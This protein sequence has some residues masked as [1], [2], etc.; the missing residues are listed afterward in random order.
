V[1]DSISLQNW[2]VP[3][4]EFYNP[5]WVWYWGDSSFNNTS[6]TKDVNTKAGHRYPYAGVYYL[7]LTQTD[8]ITGTALRCTN[9]FPEVNPDL[10]IQRKIKVIVKPIAPADFIISDSVVC[11]NEDI[12]FTDRSDLQYTRYQWYFGDGDSSLKQDPDSTAT[13]SY[14]AKGKYTIRMVPDYDPIGFVPKCVD[15]AA[16]TIRVV[17]VNA[18]FKIDSTLKP[19]FKFRNLSTGAVKYTWSLQ[20]EVDG[21]LQ[22][23]SNEFNMQH[24]WGELIGTFQVCLIAESA[25]GCTDTMCRDINNNFIALIIPY[26]V[27]TPGEDKNGDGFNDLYLVSVKGQ[28]EFE[29]KIYNR[30]GELVFETKDPNVGWDGTVMNKGKKE[31][32]AG[33]YFYIINYKL[34]NRP[35]NDGKDPISGSIT[36]IR[37]K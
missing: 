2:S 15:T 35:V 16:H 33:A 29:I 13:H 8:S 28:E 24:S 5:D 12:I 4:P 27:F 25:E 6:S 31:S 32:P 20:K 23:V 14:V 7:T 21:V 22:V 36:L 1:N 26:N 10:L 30:W 19:L 17:D 3:N 9:I 37:D 11:P 34:K 18:D